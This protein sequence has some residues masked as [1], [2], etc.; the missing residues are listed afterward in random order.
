MTKDR[1]TTIDILKCIAIIMVVLGHCIQFGCGAEYC[2]EKGYYT[3]IIFKYIY[4]FHMPLFALIS[5]YLFYY[6]VSKRNIIQI[7]QNRVKGILIPILG[8]Q[9]VINIFI[10]LQRI[11]RTHQIAEVLYLIKG[12]RGIINNMWFLWA[13]LVCS[14]IVIICHYAFKDNIISYIVAVLGTFFIYDYNMELWL[15]LLPFFIIG[16]LA[17]KNIFWN[18]FSNKYSKWFA[19]IVIAVHII[20]VLLWKNDFY[21]Y[22]KI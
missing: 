3:S 13:M 14:C 17:N 1:N 20:C 22:E 12:Y 21:I 11:L 8:W 2:T 10:A 4:S 18:I 5:G 15:W 19:F 6:S 16:Y 9:M 7:L